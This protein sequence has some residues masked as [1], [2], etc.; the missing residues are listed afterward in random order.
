MQLLGD[1][2]V[3]NE[4][5]PHSHG[6]RFF[7]DELHEGIHVTDDFDGSCDVHRM[8]KEL[9]LW[10]HVDLFDLRVVA[11]EVLPIDSLLDL[12]RGDEQSFLF[13]FGRR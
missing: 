6:F 8:E 9:R 3:G 12:D 13:I 11:V 10:L 1:L 7:S 2:D 4:L 5:S